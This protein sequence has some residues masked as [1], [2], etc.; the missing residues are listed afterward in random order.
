MDGGSPSRL[1]SKQLGVNGPDNG[2]RYFVLKSENVCQVPLEP[3]RRKVRSVTASINCPVIR[4]F[5]TLCAQTPQ[6]RSARRACVHL[7]YI[8]GFALE[9]K[10][11]IASDHEEQ[12]FEPR[13]RRDDFLNH[14]I[15]KILLLGI[16]GHVLERQDCD[17][18]LVRQGW[19]WRGLDALAFWHRC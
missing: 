15:R 11:R 10:A 8:D 18:R 2:D 17:G 6:G 9:R 12:P 1:L 19:R 16:D 3:V 14:P 4:T 5:P 13:Q 7:L